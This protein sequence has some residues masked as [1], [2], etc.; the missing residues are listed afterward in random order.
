MTQPEGPLFDKQDQ[1]RRVQELLLPGETLYAVFDCKGRGTGFVGITDKRVIAR[2]DQRR[3][4]EKHVVSIPFAHIHA[5]FVESDRG[6][7]H[8][9]SHLAFAA[10]DDD[11][12]FEFRGAEKARYAYGCI[13]TGILR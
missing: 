7:V 11:W 9:S 12:T 1:L 8:G 6:F 4:R 13:M 2:D 5:V 10:G 3:G